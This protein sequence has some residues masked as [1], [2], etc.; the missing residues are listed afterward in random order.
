MLSW[1]WIR[2]Q[3]KLSKS[4]GGQPC[5]WC[6]IFVMSLNCAWREG[7]TFSDWSPSRVWHYETKICVT[8][9]FAQMLLCFCLCDICNKVSG[10]VCIY[11]CAS[12][13]V[14]VFHQGLGSQGYL[15]PEAEEWHW[16]ECEWV[17][18]TQPLH[19]TVKHRAS[20]THT[21]AHMAIWARQTSIIS[22]SPH[23]TQ[24]LKS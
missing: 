24:E 22:N 15:L 14:E 18:E 4:Q 17:G 20:H 8:C 5:I 10:C 2:F 7:R 19:H 16:P 9:V 13:A 21:V 11:I 1:L 6:F 12:L 23:V 3:C